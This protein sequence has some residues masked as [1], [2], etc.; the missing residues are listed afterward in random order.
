MLTSGLFWGSLVV[1]WGVSIILNATFNIHIP[2]VRIAFGLIVVYFGIR[3]LTGGRPRNEG[4]R[5]DQSVVFSDGMFDGAE[6]K[7]SYSVVFGSA[8]FDLTRTALGR[9]GGRTSI[10]TVFGSSTVRVGAKQAVR[11]RVSSAFGEAKMPDGN[12]TSFGQMAWESP[13]ARSSD[14]VLDLTAEVVFG[15]LEV[16]VAK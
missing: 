9:S 5:T 2:F 6:L 12:T 16:E 3:I 10:H 7:D 13:A 1:L 4:V 11:I 14:R 8:E 15:R